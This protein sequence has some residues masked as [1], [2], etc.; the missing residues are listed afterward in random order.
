MAGYIEN[1]SLPIQPF[2]DAQ[3]SI[4]DLLFPGFTSMSAAIQGYLTI[5]PQACGAAGRKGP[6]LTGTTG[7]HKGFQV[8]QYDCLREWEVWNGSL[9]AGQVVRNSSSFLE[10]ATLQHE[11]FSLTI[12][13]RPRSWHADVGALGFRLPP[14]L[15]RHSSKFLPSCGMKLPKCHNFSGLQA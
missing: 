14:Y 5:A 15:T 13:A 11:H 6:E 10:N 2:S 4:L 7:P 8:L 9:L 3:V 1:S 12:L